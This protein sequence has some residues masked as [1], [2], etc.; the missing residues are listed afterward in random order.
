M[1]CSF[2]GRLFCEHI[3]SFE[4][5]FYDSNQ[6]QASKIAKF[7]QGVLVSSSSVSATQIL[8]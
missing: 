3:G 4:Y 8:K 5:V 6:K 1:K 2:K 7:L